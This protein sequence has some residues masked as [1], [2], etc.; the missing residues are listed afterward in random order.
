MA[1]KDNR[2][3]IE[4]LERTGDVVRI[5]LEVDWDLEAG[6]I[7]R[8]ACELQ[9]PAPFMERVKDYPDCR[10]FG[11]PIATF[12]RLAVALG[13]PPETPV[14]EICAEFDRRMSGPIKPTVIR[15]E[16]A[17]CKENILLG[18]DVDVLRFPAPMVHDGDGGRYIATW[19]AIISQ[20]PETGLTN[21]GMYRAMVHHRRAL[22]GLCLPYSDQWKIMHK[23]WSRGQAM[24][25]AIAIGMDPL[26]SLVSMTPVPPGQNE[27][28]YAGA[29]MQEPV[30]LVPAETSNLLVPAHAEIIIEGEVPPGVA[31]DEG[32]FGEY[33][34][35][36]SSPRA[37]RIVY[38]VKAITYRSNP[39]LTMSNMG[40]PVDDC[41]IG[42]S[43]GMRWTTIKRL[44]EAGIPVTD[45]YFPPE[46]V[47]HLAVVGV[48]KLYSD[49]AGQIA[50][51]LGTWPSGVPSHII[52]VE[53]DVDPFN[54]TEVLHALVT[55]CHPQ[56]GIIVRDREPAIPLVPYLSLEE[57]RWGKGVRAIFDCTWPLE[58]S[59]EVEV[60]PRVSFKDVYPDD[61][62]EKVIK[63]WKA[64]GY[65]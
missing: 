1:F 35:Y 41:D 27:V 25:F 17:P 49:V 39:I 19:H 37:P 26:S 44:R 23:Y 58:W 28:D 24:P 34:G 12:R 46:C 54:L 53:D 60:P 48:R 15:R 52:V 33:T 62:K 59:R 29:L 6:A 63:N 40:V 7:V 56:R 51:V 45:V 57:R 65:D 38:R 13:L 50:N 31:V 9:A 21:W 20:D 3:F 10:I 8:R 14:R 64:Y 43:V 61:I 4:A 30:E 11:A 47:I 5:P 42:M 36:R 18:E 32:P 55:K 16:D 22:G 2:Q